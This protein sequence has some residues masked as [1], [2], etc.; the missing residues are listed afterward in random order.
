M[1]HVRA[2]VFAVLLAAA[3]AAFSI[4]ASA[5]TGHQ[6]IWVADQTDVRTFH[7][8]CFDNARAVCKLVVT[9]TVPAHYVL[10][11][12]PG[13][14]LLTTARA[15]GYFYYEYPSVQANDYSAGGYLA[16]SITLSAENSYDG[17]TAGAV[18]VSASCQAYP[19]YSCSRGSW[20]G[21]WDSG[22]G[23]YQDWTN[24]DTTF[25]PFGLTVT[26]YLRIHVYPSGSWTRW[27]YNTGAG[28][29]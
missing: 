4:G 22:N 21:F 11:D 1:R 8:T 16:T 18:W 14:P 19:G 27:C 24:W 13:L 7:H 17:C 9:T 12:A 20:G 5:S 10:P 3:P 28:S 29:C 6:P 2:L 15:C 25:N 26:W 23:F